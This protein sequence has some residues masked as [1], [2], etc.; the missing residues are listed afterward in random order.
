M[1]DGWARDLLEQA[2]DTIAVGAPPTLDEP[3]R[4]RHRWP[5]LA[6]AAT[7]VVALG[8]AVVVGQLGQE[9]APG[10]HRPLGLTQLDVPF[11]FGMT[12]E[13]A[14]EA[15]KAAGFTPVV[16]LEANCLEVEGRV[17][18]VR[19]A[20]GGEA[21]VSVP[22]T[23]S[24]LCL[25]TDLHDRAVAWQLID[26]ATGRGPGPERDPDCCP[27][28]VMSS[29]ARAATQ[30]APAPGIMNV[31]PE[32]IVRP[33]PRGFV[34]AIGETFNHH[35]RA[36]E[37][38]TVTVRDGRVV[39]VRPGGTLVAEHDEPPVDPDP[40]V[41]SGESNADRDGVGRRFLDFA[42]GRSD[43]L[44]VDTPVK[45]YLGNRLI[46]TISADQ[47]PDRTAWRVCASYGEGS[48]PFSAIETLARNGSHPLAWSNQP[49][50]SDFCPDGLNPGPPHD[51]GGSYAVVLS[52]P[53]P[54]SCAQAFEVQVWVNDVA[55][56][57][58]VNLLVGSP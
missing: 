7:V 54:Q 39:G 35:F 50:R 37:R 46:T 48:C 38:A 42:L 53:E 5:I 27:Q 33:V 28:A 36:Y 29:L 47:A 24:G 14:T 22:D 1:T 20:E 8:A 10:T 19:A 51:T 2:G 16:R 55:Q 44:P 34:L 23:D 25:S 32:L 11:T 15:V 49:H 21:V 17:I 31:S 41:R 40:S 6:A 18:S 52:I 9:P 45:L 30:W 56:I 13:Q 26:L 4:R 57:V 3:R 58:A 12:T 43:S